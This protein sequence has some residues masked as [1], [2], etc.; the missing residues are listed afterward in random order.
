MILGLTSSL[1][2]FKA[3]KFGPGLNILVATRH[4][5]SGARDT[6]NGTGK[7]SMIELVHYLLAEKRD[8]HDD[9]HKEELVEQSFEGT[10]KSA[11]KIVTISKKAGLS[12]D[13][14]TLNGVDIS[15]VDLRRTL[16][17]SWFQLTRDITDQF[18]SPT[19]GALFAY[20]A[21]KER[22]GA[23]ASPTQNSSKQ[24]GW[25][26][27]VNL[28]YL[29]GLD[30]NLPQKLQIAKDKKKQT[31]MLAKMLKSGYLS[32]GQLDLG[33]MQTRLDLL[34][35]EIGSKRDEVMSATI[36]DGYRTHEI[37]ANNLA[38]VI[39]GFNEANLRDLDLLDE[40]NHA[41]AEVEDADISDIEALYQEVGVFFGDKVKKRFDQVLSFHA[42]VASNRKAHLSKER[43]HANVRLS[44]RKSDIVHLQDQLSEK[45]QI[46]RSG[47]AIERLSLL[48]SELTKLETER[49]NLDAQI[50]KLR[51]IAEVQ[52]KLKRS[53]E[54]LLDLI[55]ADIL[56]RDEPRKL[57][58][59]TFGEISQFLYNEP[60]QLVMNRSVREAG[61][62]IETDIAGKKSGGKNHMQV[63]CFDWTLAEVAQKYD[64][65]PGFIVHDSHIFDGVDGRQ[66]G[67]AL[68]LAQKKCE[69]LGIQYIVAMNSD[70]LQKIKN[71]EMIDDEPIFDPSPYILPTSLSDQE[72]GGLFGI[73][74]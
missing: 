3:L 9:F 45:T 34:E 5:D 6:R 25:D 43:E 64:R 7:T 30:W 66:I 62:V 35:I 40:I 70:D 69:E 48:Q 37:E 2:T 32:G 51:D 67:L 27:Q 57:A 49:A 31:D 39:K 54:G 65:S 61:L 22:N 41:M 73:R 10:F 20:F 12:R 8:K 15:P 71:E 50:P 21:R 60:G 53:I 44:D 11:G 74:F 26:M 4:K 55:E 14:L 46:L 16:S 18:Y 36:I 42:K 63:F 24:L 17:V 1:P 13:A 33:K 72:D 59:K 23:F 29:F 56:E 19:F 38:Q 47:V 68:N 58:V 28:A 52:K